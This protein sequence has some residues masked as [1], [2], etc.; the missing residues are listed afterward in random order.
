[1]E[2]AELSYILLIVFILF[3]FV[4][5]LLAVIVETKYP[6][7]RNLKNATPL[8]K[9]LVDLRRVFNVISIVTLSYFLINY[10]FNRYIKVI[11]SLLLLISVKYFVIDERIIFYFIEDNA[12]NNRVVYLIDDKLD[13]YLDIICL[14]FAINVFNRIFLK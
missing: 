9:K 11:L 7:Y 4:K 8:W 14:W 12:E 10:K 5:K 1:M 3:L 2:D 13:F 6:D